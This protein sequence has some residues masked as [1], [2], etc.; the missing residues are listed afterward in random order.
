MLDLQLL[1]SDLAGTAQRLSDRG[2][3]LDVAG[4]EA[5]EKERKMIQGE[6]QDLQ[7]RRNQ[8]SK[9][10][11]QMK[12]KGEDASEL[13]AQVTA[14][15]DQLKSLEQKLADVQTRLNDFLGV[16]PNVPHSSVPHGK[17]SDDNPEVRRVGE[18]RKLDFEPKDHVDI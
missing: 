15:A 17:S 5:L 2:Y 11:G 14:Q 18:P 9:Q 1:R 10:I 12:G 4:F 8:L 7:A 16:I 6:T 13:M 3:T